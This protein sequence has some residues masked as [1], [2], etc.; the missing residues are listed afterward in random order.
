MQ[1]ASAAAT[2]CAAYYNSR[3]AVYSNNNNL[4][5]LISGYCI[6]L[7][8]ARGGESHLM[9]ERVRRQIA[10]TRSFA[11]QDSSQRTLGVHSVKYIHQARAR[12]HTST[13][14]FFMHTILFSARAKNSRED[15]DICISRSFSLHAGETLLRFCV[16]CMYG[17]CG[18]AAAYREAAPPAQ[19][20]RGIPVLLHK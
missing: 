6:V 15:V 13:F 3:R 11:I 8:R 2:G 19:M 18:A 10:I 5:S 1:P 17:S 4:I 16:C 7:C 12:A 20:K 9:D 14:L